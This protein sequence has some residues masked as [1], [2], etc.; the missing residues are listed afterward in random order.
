MKFS[1]ERLDL[2][3]KINHLN[4][5]VP[6]KNTMLILTNFLI[7][8]NNINNILKITATDLEITVT[9]EIEADILEAGKIAVSAK[10]FNDIINSFPNALVYFTT[11]EDELRISCSKSKFSLPC[12]DPEQFPLIPNE[13][14]KNALE[15][16]TELFSKMV[17]STAFATSTR[18]NRPILT[19]ILWKITADKQLMAATDSSK[20]AEYSIFHSS[21]IKHDEIDKI[22]PIKSPNFI[23]RITENS[24]KKIKFVFKPNRVIFKYDCFTIYTQVIEGKYPDYSMA[25]PTENDNKLVLNRLE[26]ITSLKRIS[27]TSSDFDFKVQLD[28]QQE[29][30]FLSSSNSNKETGNEELTP[31][32]NN[33]SAFSIAFNYKYLLSILNVMLNKN[34]VF[35]FKGSND[36]ILIFNEN[37][38]EK[39]SA[40]FLLMPLRIK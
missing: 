29:T 39:T 2:L 26:L 38:D 11:K 31:I 21:D 28:I 13:D 33:C 4:S 12:V 3:P 36:A 32:F 7:E 30:L 15:I 35:L 1:I 37:E 23:D 20:I 8:A 34:V 16:D 27:L 24:K 5:I 22:I 10:S 14:M 9:V 19:G 6:T 25:F 18:I 40:R 17:T